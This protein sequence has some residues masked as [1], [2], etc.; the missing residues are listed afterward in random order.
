MATSIVTYL[1]I[2]GVLYWLLFMGG[3]NQVKGMLG[4]LGGNSQTQT[5]SQSNVRVN[6][7]DAQS[8][9]NDIQGRVQSIIQKSNVSPGS[10]NSGKNVSIQRKDDRGN[11]FNVQS[12]SLFATRIPRI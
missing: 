5:N 11:Q 10:V 8:M 12:N 6:G 4:G 1:I 9:V 2:G 3:L 7:Q